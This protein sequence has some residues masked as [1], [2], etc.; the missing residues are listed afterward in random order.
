MIFLNASIIINLF[1]M[2]NDFGSTDKIV[3]ILSYQEYKYCFK[4]FADYKTNCKS[5][6]QQKAITN[7]ANL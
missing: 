4:M 7:H 1:S 3:I 2:R 6:L 5:I